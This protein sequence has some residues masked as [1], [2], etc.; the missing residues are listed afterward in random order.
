MFPALAAI[1]IIGSVLLMFLWEFRPLIERKVFPIIIDL[2]SVAEEK[3][4]MT[5]IYL[6][7]YNIENEFQF[8]IK[9]AEKNIWLARPHLMSSSFKNLMK[10][11][12]DSVRVR[13]ILADKTDA[14]KIEAI[15]KELDHSAQIFHR[16]R[17]HF[18]MLLSEQRLALSSIDFFSTIPS[19]VH[20][21]PIISS[22]PKIIKDAQHYCEAFHEE[23][24]EFSKNDQLD[25]S[26]SITSNKIKSIFVNTSNGL[27]DLV[28]NLLSSAKE[29]VLLISPYLTNDVTELLLNIIPRDVQVKFITW[30]NWEQWVNDQSDPEALEMLLCD[31]IVVYT[32]P[33]LYANCIVV[34][35]KSAIISSQNLT[36][37]S[38]FSRDEVGIYTQN[39]TLIGSI[40]KRIEEWKPK[41]RF[42]MELLEKE[43]AKFDAYLVKDDTIIPSIIDQPAEEDLTTPSAD[44]FI[45][46]PLLGFSAITQPRPETTISISQP[47]KL[48]PSPPQKEPSWLEDIVYVGKKRTIEYVRAAQHQIKRKGSVTIRA[49]GRLIYRAVD[50]AEQLRM[51]EELE[52]IMKKD[53]IQI[54]TYY[55]T[56]K[57]KKWGGISQIAI[58]LHQKN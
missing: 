56:G 44:E 54:E 20:E 37:K 6:A 1:L 57:E 18:K 25:I 5:P 2:L 28:H 48:V 49:R 3:L 17:I 53:S 19:A 11:V 58:T 23:K 45:A 15:T 7:E 12:D 30:V 41:Q 34:D 22:N 16:P 36:T 33:N 51:L 4:L 21:L 52:L 38:W 32:C 42:T 27:N 8:L 47:E 50:V 13:L 24:S 46:P 55:P 26:S 35:N 39:P 10:K 29:T 9:Q 31:R 43:I 14:D 40:L